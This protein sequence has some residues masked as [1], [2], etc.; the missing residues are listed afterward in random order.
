M[1]IE[2]VQKFYEAVNNDETLRQKLTEFSLKHRGEAMDEAN[3]DKLLQQE[4]L[5]FAQKLGFEFSLADL[6]AFGEELKNRDH[7]LSDEELQL[8]TGGGAEAGL[9]CVIVGANEG[10]HTLGLCCFLGFN[11]EGGFCCIIGAGTK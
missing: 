8:V 2:N 1:S 3:S 10:L 11:P 6:K 9:I 7:G 4:F 5:P